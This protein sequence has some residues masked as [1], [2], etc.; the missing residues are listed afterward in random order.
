MLAVL[1]AAGAAAL[2]L[3]SRGDAAA[4]RVPQ[5]VVL[6]WAALLAVAAVG[7]WRQGRR[8]EAA[9]RAVAESEARLYQAQKMDAVGRLAGGIAHDINNYLAGIR[10][11]CELLLAAA[12]R[13]ALDPD[14]TAHRLEAIVGTILK[15]SSLVERLLTFGR[16]QVGLPE[17]V[18]LNEVVETFA[19]GL[20][21]GLGRGVT[22]ET[23]LAP[24]LWPVEIDL[25]QVEQAL[26][27]LV[28]NARDALVSTAS[29]EGRIVV[30]T[31]NVA[32]D[33]DAPERPERPGD[34]VALAVADDGPGI[35][36]AIRDQVFDP[37]FSTKATTG[38]SGLGLATVYAVVDEAGGTIEVDS[39][40]ADEPA[41]PADPAKAGARRDR[42][43]TTVRI[44]LP[45]ASGRLGGSRPGA[46]P[47]SVRR[48]RGAR[49]ER[50]LL[51]DDE[52]DVR[53]ATREL[54]AESGYRVEAV[55]GADEALAAAAAARREGDPFDL[56]L[57][58]V[59]IG[60]QAGPDLVARL[61]AQG[62]VRAL[63]MSGYTDRIA[64]RTGPGRG[65]AFFLK[66]PF[67]GE[68]LLRMVRELLEEP[69][70]E[71]GA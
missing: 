6:A 4:A 27:N 10:T 63:Y 3:L 64:L 12:R 39:R 71:P 32:G 18:D 14:A 5:L 66:K 30:T 53:S 40:T 67:S 47:A 28:V 70:D 7:A 58:D 61:R 25:S 42:P 49:G 23:R 43:G 22:L 52:P 29:G 38:A 69:L 62:P 1:L 44:L 33:P 20:G 26:A 54:L 48:R 37:F 41:H 15:A 59:R 60:E 55:A 9:E 19:G 45:R 57:T 2:A 51:V 8:R 50:I 36:A 17:V 13:G 31:A 65:D 11:H 56:V 24:D 46:S 16:R 34:H 35:P 21:G 68:G